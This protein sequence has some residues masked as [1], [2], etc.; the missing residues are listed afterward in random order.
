VTSQSDLERQ[1]LA[2]LDAFIE[3]SGGQ[4]GFEAAALAER[5]V[6]GPLP[7]GEDDEKLDPLVEQFHKRRGSRTDPK[8]IAPLLAPIED[9][10]RPLVRRTWELLWRCRD[11]ELTLPE[12]RSV[13]R[14]WDEDRQAYTAHMDW[15]ARGGLRRT[16]QTPRQAVLMLRRLEDAK[17][18]LE[19]EEACDDPLRMISYLL[20]NKAVRGRVIRV[21]LVHREMAKR[22]MVAR[23][24]LTL[25]SP[26]SCPIPLGRKL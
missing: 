6:V 3:P 14:R 16:R 1:S 24:L 5:Y 19:A 22:R 25:H 18:R 21:D 11:R 4:H 17:K 7:S 2:A 15:M 9:H 20:E 26:D 13:A 10:Y 23:P 8:V 12:A